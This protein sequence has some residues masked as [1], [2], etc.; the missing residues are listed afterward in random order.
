MNAKAL[1][2][3]NIGAEIGANK[4]SLDMMLVRCS[5]SKEKARPTEYGTAI[6]PTCFNYIISCHTAV[7]VV[8]ACI[9]VCISGI[10]L[11]SEFTDLA[12][13]LLHKGCR[14]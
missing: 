10:Y 11:Q 8:A 13:Y 6:A 7:R 2:V 1:A 4:T 3:V 12:I 9:R 5:K 14:P